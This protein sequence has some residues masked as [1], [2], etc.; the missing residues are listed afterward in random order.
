[1]P[2]TV[3]VVPAHTASRLIR[4]GKFARVYFHFV[5]R[6]AASLVSTPKAR[7]QETLRRL[8]EKGGEVAIELDAEHGDATILPVEA[9]TP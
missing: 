8:A 3:Q 6:G 5:T 7:A 2:V 1:M 4:S 9:R